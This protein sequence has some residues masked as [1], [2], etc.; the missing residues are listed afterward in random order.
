MPSQK[1]LPALVAGKSAANFQLQLMAK[2]LR[3][4]SG[5][6]IAFGVPMTI[7]NVVRNLF[8]VAVNRYGGAA[9]IEEI[10]HLYE[11]MAGIE[12]KPSGVHG[13]A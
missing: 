10:A 6:G 3:L 8:E 5:L 1:L 4:A 12:Y 9:N 11:S 7:S 13:A 2:D